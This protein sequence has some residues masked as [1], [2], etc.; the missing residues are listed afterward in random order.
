MKMGWWVRYGMVRWGSYHRRFIA[1]RASKCT[2]AGGG[3]VGVSGRTARHCCKVLVHI[4][5]ER[6]VGLDT[7]K[8][9][10]LVVYSSRR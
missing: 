2:G 7:E 9:A 1:Q 10:G 3:Q 4:G 5:I 6:E 8:G